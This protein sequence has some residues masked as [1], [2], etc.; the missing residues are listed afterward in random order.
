MPTPGTTSNAAVT[1]SQHRMLDLLA[2]AD[3][4]P[5]TKAD[6]QEL[7]AQ[8]AELLRLLGPPSK[9][10]LTGAEVQR[11]YSRLQCTCLT[12]QLGP[13]YCEKHSA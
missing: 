9:I 2:G 13:D 7:A 4:Q 6:V 11:E 1:L 5:A 3:Q 12:N 8:L 10:I